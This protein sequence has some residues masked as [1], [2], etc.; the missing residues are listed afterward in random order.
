MATSVLQSSVFDNLIH[1][2]E[3]AEAK[4]GVLNNSLS[5]EK[6]PRC[7][8]GVLEEEI[9]LLKEE[10]VSG[11]A[12][13]EGDNDSGLHYYTAVGELEKEVAELRKLSEVTQ[14]S[15]ESNKQ[16]L[17]D[18]KKM[19]EDQ[20]K[21]VTSLEK[22]TSKEVTVDKSSEE[23]QKLTADIRANKVILDELKAAL[24][25]VVDSQT[26]TETESGP[27]SVGML[28]QLLWKQFVTAGPEQ[29][30]V[31]LSQLDFS[32]ENET[33]EQLLSSGIVTQPDSDSLKLV[34]FTC[35]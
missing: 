23:K 14:H 18:I 13:A 29:A 12:G 17:E 25:D 24:R 32:L 9:M 22:E 31:K 20:R 8:K 1:E 4:L 5:A 35:A 10:A 6:K 11:Y 19:V 7:E 16:T 26:R 33:I 2:I 15:V 27:N 21:I 3:T 28:L 30:V 34:D